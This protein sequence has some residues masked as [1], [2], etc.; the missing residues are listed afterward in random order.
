MTD[1][2]SRGYS[3]LTTGVSMKLATKRL[4]DIPLPLTSRPPLGAH[5]GPRSARRHGAAG[6]IP[7]ERR[8]FPRDGRCHDGR[9]LSALNQLS[10]SSGKT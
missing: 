2:A 6:N 10:I 3:C 1:C 5:V 7:H 8:H 4:S 9:F